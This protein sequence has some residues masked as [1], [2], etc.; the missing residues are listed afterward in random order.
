MDCCCGKVEEAGQ[1]AK[2]VM[3]KVSTGGMIS[4][5][6]LKTFS[7]S[8][9][10]LSFP[11]CVLKT[12][13]A[14]RH[15]MAC[16]YFFAGGHFH[17]F[18][19]MTFLCPAIILLDCVCTAHN[20]LLLRLLCK[21]SVCVFVCLTATVFPFVTVHLTRFNLILR[22]ELLKFIR[23]RYFFPSRNGHMSSIKFKSLTHSFVDLAQCI[24]LQLR[25][26]MLWAV[27]TWI[28]AEIRYLVAFDLKLSF[29][30]R[31]CMH[32]ANTF[33]HRKFL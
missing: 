2:R 14:N 19:Q 15:G 31:N 13:H 12:N 1:K 6:I 33:L 4:M 32:I 5:S 10:V 23:W 16:C 28:L 7:C 9:S 27:C 21:T 26:L 29:Y 22:L 18:Q 11:L 20:L 30:L 24:I 17:A 8:V 3:Y 25:S